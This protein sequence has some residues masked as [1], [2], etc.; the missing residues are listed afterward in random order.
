MTQLSTTASV[1]NAVLAFINPEQTP[2]IAWDRDDL[3]IPLIEKVKQAVGNYDGSLRVTLSFTD[4]EADLEYQFSN[5]CKAISEILKTV[6]NSTQSIS[7]ET[8]HI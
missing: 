7:H 3:A 2:K 5:V 1:L 4:S 8:E 6:H